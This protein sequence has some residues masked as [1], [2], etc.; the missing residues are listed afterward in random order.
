MEKSQLALQTDEARRLASQA[1]PDALDTLAEDAVADLH[2]RIRK[3]RNK[4]SGI[5]L[6]RAA[7]NVGATEGRGPG[8]GAGDPKAGK[9]SGDGDSANMNAHTKKRRADTRAQ[10]ARRQAKPEAGA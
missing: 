10:G 8:R 3:A 6:R 5:H 4:Y 2:R 1:T 7:K 9:A